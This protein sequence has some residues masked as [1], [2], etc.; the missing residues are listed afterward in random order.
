M[1][2]L[3][4][5][6]V[7]AT[8][9][10]ARE[11]NR[12]ELKNSCVMLLISVGNP[13]YEGEKLQ[14]T[15]KLIN[16]SFNKCVL[17]LGDSLQRHNILAEKNISLEEARNIANHFGD[18]WLVRNEKYYRQLKINYEIVRWDKW[19]FD[20]D[21]S[22]SMLQINNLYNE[23]VEYKATFDAS[24]SEYIKRIISRSPELNSKSIIKQYSAMCLNYLKEEC[25]VMLLWANEFHPYTV[26]PS[27]LSPAMIKTRELL[28]SP[29]YNEI[30]K[31]LSLRFKR[32]TTP[33]LVS[34]K[35]YAANAV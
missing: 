18:E 2:I 33:V 28:I 3:K 32:Y 4:N 22:S 13:Y 17:T 20:P 35:H 8:F 31:P 12:N 34:S 21:F 19:L 29:I 23:N 11:I 7:K 24:I 27:L 25:A 26:Y 10:K 1:E 16:S 5:E 30:L 14:A 15:L 9:M 6:I